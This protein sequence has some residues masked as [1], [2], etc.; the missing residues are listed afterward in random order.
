MI[1]GTNHSSGMFC[2]CCS[3]WGDT[4]AIYWPLGCLDMNAA[5]DNIQYF[6]QRTAK[7]KLCLCFIKYHATKINVGLKNGVF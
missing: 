6:V 5:A 3:N 4:C 1:R 7:A 2:G